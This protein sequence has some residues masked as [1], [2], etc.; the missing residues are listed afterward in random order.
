MLLF[1][2]L[3]APFTDVRKPSSFYDRKANMGIRSPNFLAFGKDH[4]LPKHHMGPQPSQ[5]TLRP[6]TKALTKPGQDLDTLGIICS[7]NRFSDSRQR[8]TIDSYPRDYYYESYLVDSNT[9][10]E[11]FNGRS[12]SELPYSEFYP[13]QRTSDARRLID[14]RNLDCDMPWPRGMDG[15]RGSRRGAR[16]GVRFAGVRGR[17]PSFVTAMTK[18]HRRLGIAYDLYSSFQSGY[19][20]DVRAVRGYM[21]KEALARMW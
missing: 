3:T 21:R 12:N 5:L 20:D 18:L 1:Q 4:R 16:P 7:M 19:N 11:Y 17:D 15:I 8:Q 10:N 9:G 13:R 6:S 14:D 2:S